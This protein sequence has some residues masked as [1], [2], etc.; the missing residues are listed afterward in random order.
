MLLENAI[1]F[2]EN[3]VLKTLVQ[4]EWHALPRQESCH[5]GIDIKTGKVSPLLLAEDLPLSRVLGDQSL[6]QQVF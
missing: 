6:K 1:A 2:Q 5:Q 4:E 3:D